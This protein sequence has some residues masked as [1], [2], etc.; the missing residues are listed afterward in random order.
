LLV[1]T[2]ILLSA[3]AGVWALYIALRERDWLSAVSFGV[4]LA[5]A[6]FAA[7]ALW[8]NGNPGHPLIAAVYG[9]PYDGFGLYPLAF[10]G[11]AA[12]A[13]AIPLLALAYALTSGKARQIS[14]AA[15]PLAMLGLWAAIRIA[16]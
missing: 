15:G 14:A 10:Y 12:L 13:P 9:L 4:L 3:V 5:A 16:G 6:A 1:G 8:Y 2:A 7:Y 11:S